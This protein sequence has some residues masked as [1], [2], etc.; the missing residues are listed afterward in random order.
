MAETKASFA[1]YDLLYK[2]FN[3]YDSILVDRFMNY[4]LNGYL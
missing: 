1:T 2:E 4:F 3:G